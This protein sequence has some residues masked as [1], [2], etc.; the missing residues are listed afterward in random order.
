MWLMIVGMTLKD[1]YQDVPK[2]RKRKRNRNRIRR[3]PRWHWLVKQQEVPNDASVEE[4]LTTTIP[5]AQPGETAHRQ[6]NAPNLVQGKAKRDVVT[7]NKFDVLQQGGSLNC[8]Y[9][10]DPGVTLHPP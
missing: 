7:P 4:V 3:N 5:A 1:D 10:A 8:S 6:M 9:T 2:R